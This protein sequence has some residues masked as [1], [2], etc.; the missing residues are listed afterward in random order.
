[1]MNWANMLT[2]GRIFLIPAVIVTDHSPGS[3]PSHVAAWLFVGAS[4]TD[5]LDG[6]VAR[7]FNMVTSMGK[8]LDPIADKILVSAALFLL[9][10]HGLLP[11]ILAIIV[12]ARE[13]AVSGL[14]AVAAAQNIIIP[15]ENLGKAKMVFQTIA[16]SLLLDNDRHLTIPGSNFLLNLH[17]IGLLTFW[18]ALI[19]TLVSGFQYLSW[20]R[21]LVSQDSHE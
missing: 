1:M 9:V 10:A 3:G 19:L 12:V 6:F 11:A 20:Y 7:R 2:L 16:I 15:A 13:F 21:W 5:I 17:W 4:L 8:L 18:I 14:R